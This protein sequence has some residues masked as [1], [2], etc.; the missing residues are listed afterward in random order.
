[1][2]VISIVALESLVVYNLLEW[3]DI[4]FEKGG[5][6]RSFERTCIQS[7]AHTAILQLVVR[8]SMWN[9]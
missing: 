9:I 2:E 1:M 4:L 7:K 5:I 3:S 8:W 6:S